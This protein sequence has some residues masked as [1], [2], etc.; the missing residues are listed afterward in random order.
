MKN[1]VVVY[2]SVFGNTEKVAQALGSALKLAG[3]VEVLKVAAVNESHLRNLALLIVGSPT[4]SFQPTPAVKEFLKKI[5]KDQLKDVLVAA[6]DTRIALEDIKGKVFRLLVNTGGYAAPV[7][8]KE[9]KKKGGAPAVVPQG[10][11]VTGEQGPLK[12]N[13]L[14]RAADWARQLSSITGLRTD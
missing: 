8:L 14:E 1:I 2:D 5:A 12:E 10:F 3:S 6:F 4:R 7:M 13:E 9:L 11:Y